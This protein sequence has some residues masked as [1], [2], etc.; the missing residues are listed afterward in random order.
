VGCVRGEISPAG[1]GEFG[2]LGEIVSS[3]HAADTPASRILYIH[4][5]V[6]PRLLV[7]QS[8]TLR[9]RALAAASPCEIST[10]GNATQYIS[11]TLTCPEPQD[12]LSQTRKTPARNDDSQR[13]DSSRVHMARAVKKKVG[14]AESSVSM[15]QLYPGMKIS[16]RRIRAAQNKRG[17]RKQPEFRQT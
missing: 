2:Q 16:V 5:R 17:R 12:R 10:P 3:V 6:A 13:G 1:T 8:A 11:K 4:W 15:R 9:S 7:V 14:M